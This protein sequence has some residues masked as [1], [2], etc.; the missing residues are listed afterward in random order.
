VTFSFSDDGAGRWLSMALGSVFLIQIFVPVGGFIANGPAYSVPLAILPFL[1]LLAAVGLRSPAALLVGFPVSILPTLATIPPLFSVELREPEA[2]MRLVGTMAVYL[3]IASAWAA[4]ADRGEIQISDRMEGDVRG[5][6]MRRFVYSRVPILV[7]LF[8]VPAYAILVDGAIVA[9][10]AQ[11][12]PD[13][14]TIG[15]VFIATLLFFVWCAVAYSMF[16]VPS[17]NLEYDRRRL[18]K[19]IASMLVPYDPKRWWRVGAE[20]GGVLIVCLSAMYI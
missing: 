14:E 17:L 12:H 6:W 5:R 2:L 4:S 18:K 10:I 13:S 20:C 7:L 11:S 3:A 15:Q 1:V 9:T 16:I 8:A 19:T